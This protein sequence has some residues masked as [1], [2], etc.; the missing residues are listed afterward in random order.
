MS[1]RRPKSGVGLADYSF[2]LPLVAALAAVAFFVSFYATFGRC[3]RPSLVAC[4]APRFTPLFAAMKAWQAGT[5]L[6]ALAEG[7]VLRGNTYQGH[8]VWALCTGLYFLAFAAAVAVGLY[9]MRRSL[10][11]Y[12]R[13][14]RWVPAAA[15]AASAAFA[16][17]MHAFQ[18]APREVPDLWTQ[19]VEATV[20]DD[21]RNITEVYLWHDALGFGMVLLLACAS[22]TTLVF[23]ANVRNFPAGRDERAVRRLALRRLGSQAASLRLILYAG[24]SFLVVATLRLSS[25][26]HWGLSYLQPT[27]SNAKDAAFVYKN[28][29]GMVTSVVTAQGA[30]YTLLLISVYVPAALVINRRAHAYYVPARKAPSER[31]PES[32]GEEEKASAGAPP[33]ALPVSQQLLRIAAILGPLL[34]GPLGELLGSLK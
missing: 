12:P 21:V 13:A 8:L 6:G 19:L 28:I 9:V 2:V 23:P 24:T 25:L 32:E 20:K 15:A 1:K 3:L 30:F 4:D 29:Y 22:A 11:D 33:Y 34:A 17:L 26:L 16:V 7:E 18:A 5:T 31:K 10:A 14:R 27:P